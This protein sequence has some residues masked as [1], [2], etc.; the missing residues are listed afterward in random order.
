MNGESKRP[1]LAH[2]WIGVA[3]YLQSAPK[4]DQA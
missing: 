1:P 2:V 3:F 4:V